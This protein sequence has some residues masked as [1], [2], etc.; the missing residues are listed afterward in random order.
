[1]ERISEERKLDEHSETIEEDKSST[2]EEG[3][4]ASASTTAS[5]TETGKTQET[6]IEATR[7]LGTVTSEERRVDD[8]AETNDDNKA[9]S[10]EGRLHTSPATTATAKASE[11]Q[12][13][14]AT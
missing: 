10:Q 3:L 4:Y 5:G 2:R 12:E 14:I 1:L 13:V 11:A 7:Q 6:H 8:Y 9:Y